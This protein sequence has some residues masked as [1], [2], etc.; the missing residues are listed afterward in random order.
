MTEARKKLIETFGCPDGCAE[1]EAAIKNICAAWETFL[2]AKEITID[3]DAPIDVMKILVDPAHPV[4]VV[5][6]H[7]YSLETFL[8]RTLN[9]AAR[10]GDLSKVH[11]LGPYSQALYLIVSVTGEY[12]EDIKA[13]EMA[14]VDLY[15]GCNMTPD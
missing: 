11:T 1:L 15:R 8:Y 14:G 7:L 13:E 5:L 9:H 3:R 10:F 2:N 4:T 6:L 12:R